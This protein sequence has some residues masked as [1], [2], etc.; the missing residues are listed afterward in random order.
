M[1]QEAMASGLVVVGT[2]TGGTQE[3]LRDGQTGLTFAPG[4][5]NGLAD[6]VVRLVSD[7]ELRRRLVQAGRQT[8]LEKFTLDRM[9]LEID[10]YLNESLADSSR[11]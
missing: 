8:V 3:I 1:T 11:S 10:A 4:D 2:T 6:Q 5:A 9:V 7:P